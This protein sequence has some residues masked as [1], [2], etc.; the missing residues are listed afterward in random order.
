MP[1]SVLLLGVSHRCAYDAYPLA[2]I[3]AVHPVV[4]VDTAPPAWARPYLAGHIAADP[5][6]AAGTAE[7]V[8]RYASRHE[9]SGV[10]T[11]TREFL[12]GAARVAARLTSPGIPYETA[13]ACTDPAALQ[14]LLARHKIPPA[15][16]E[17]TDAPLVGAE[18]VVLDDEVRIAALTR[19]APGPPPARQSMRHSVHAHDGLLHNPFLRHTVERTVRAL[20]LAHTVVHIGLRLT[21]RGP[22]VTDVVPHLPGDLIPLLVERATGVDLARAAAALATG[23]LPD[24]APT[25][26][27]AAAI[28]FAYPATTGRLTHLDMDPAAAYEP[29]AER[30]V[31]T[32]RP[33][34]HVRAAAHADPDDRLAHWVAAGETPTDCADTLRRMAHHLSAAVNPTVR[35]HAA[36]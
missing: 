27:R 15:G 9:V 26:Q 23:G 12:P 11:W 4:L 32:R 21:A 1:P 17:D 33:G 35:P 6:E 20:G 18:A 2:R 10:L 14:M 16:R 36:A 34:D 30:M 8:G 5:G 28:Q 29:Y 31:L 22:R 24:V 13:A 19:T 3:A 7:A 25:R